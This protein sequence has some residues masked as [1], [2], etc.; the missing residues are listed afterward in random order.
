MNKNVFAAALFSI[1]IPLSMQSANAQD[2]A[3]RL[4]PESFTKTIKIN[5]RQDGEAVDIDVTNPK[6][7]WVLQELEL[8]IRYQIK[9]V[10]K[11]APP[12]QKN[13]KPTQANSSFDFEAMKRFVD[14]L[15]DTKRIKI[16]AL[17]GHS[18]KT[19]IESRKGEQVVEIVILS[20]R[21][22]SHTRFE[23]F[24]AKIL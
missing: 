18:T 9:P 16:N 22:R 12:T 5:W 3:T 13:K 23:Q 4:L 17:A 1:L 20:A 15:P 7:E 14:E 21:G 2:E 19:N 10:P 8:E 24:K 6:D 11:T